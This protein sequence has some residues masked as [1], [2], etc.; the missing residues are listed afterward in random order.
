MKEE[1]DKVIAGQ[2]LSFD[3]AHKVMYSIMSGNENNSKIASLLTAL[4]IKGETSEEVAG[5]VK[6]MREV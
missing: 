4:K 2:S 1:L 6:A 3:E 5:F